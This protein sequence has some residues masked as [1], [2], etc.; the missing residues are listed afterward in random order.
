MI[1]YFSINIFPRNASFMHNCMQMEKNCGFVADERNQI[2]VMLSTCV[3]LRT[4]TAF[5][6]LHG[7]GNLAN[8]VT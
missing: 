8:K 2:Y 1:S 4:L 6:Q 5:K 3:C 7:H